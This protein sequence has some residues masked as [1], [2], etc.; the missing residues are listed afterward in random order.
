MKKLLVVLFVFS[1]VGGYVFGVTEDTAT[2]NINGT[3]DS[4]AEI[5]VENTPA[6]DIVLLNGSD[7]VTGNIF[8]GD[9]REK[10]NT[11]YTVSY[12]T[13]GQLVRHVGTEAQADYISFSVDYTGTEDGPS[14]NSDGVVKP[15]NITLGSY[16]V[17]NTVP[18]AGS[19]EGSI[20]FTISAN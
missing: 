4:W 2:L 19:Y 6:E 18:Q 10:A 1:I 8:V 11:T 16:S 7:L 3:V 12:T 9:T 20:E 5:T 15:V 14:T 13:D 17:E